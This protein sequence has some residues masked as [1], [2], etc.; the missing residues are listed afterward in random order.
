MKEPIYADEVKASAEKQQEK[1]F[2]H[3]GTLRPHAGHTLFEINHATQEVKQAEY[4]TQDV[5]FMD[6]ANKN[7]SLKKK[8]LVKEGCE[9]VSAL[10]MKNAIKKYNKG[11]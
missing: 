8:L 6:A 9:Y 7:I 11:R 5:D 2:K 4:L 10:N 1:Q 3:L